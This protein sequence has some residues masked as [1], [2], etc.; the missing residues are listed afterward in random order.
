MRKRF[1]SYLLISALPLLS[2]C[3]QE[4]PEQEEESISPVTG[5]GSEEGLVKLEFSAALED[6]SRTWLDGTTVKWRGTDKI[7]VIDKTSPYV[8][9]FDNTDVDGGA[10]CRFIG[11]AGNAESW[12]VVYPPS[13]FAKKTSG[14]DY[15]NMFWL[16]Y[17]SVQTAVRGSF[18]NESYVTIA[19]TTGKSFTMRPLSSLLKITL[20]YN[21]IKQIRVDANTS[22]DFAPSGTVRPLAGRF[23]VDITDPYAH[24]GHNGS[25]EGIELNP[26]VGET[27]FPAG[28]YYIPI[29]DL[30]NY[31][32]IKNIRLTFIRQDDETASRTKTGASFRFAPGEYTDFGT[33][34]EGLSWEYYDIVF[35]V[36]GLDDH[37]TATNLRWP[38]ASWKTSDDGSSWTEKADP[39]ANLQAL[40]S[41]LAW[42]IEGKLKDSGH[43]LRLHSVEAGGTGAKTEKLRY[44]ENANGL[45]LSGHVGSYI[46]FPAMPNR[47]LLRVIVDY[48]GTSTEGGSP[49]MKGYS[50]AACPHI[51]TTAGV[52]ADYTLTRDADGFC[53]DYNLYSTADG[54]AYRYV[55]SHD[56]GTDWSGPR[57]QRIRLYY[58]KETRSLTL[59]EP[60]LSVI[61]TTL[62]QHENTLTLTGA[63]GAYDMGIVVRHAL[64]TA[65]PGAPEGHS[66][67]RVI[68][69][70]VTPTVDGDTQ[71]Y[72][73]SNSLPWSVTRT[74]DELSG[75]D[76][77]LSEEN[78]V[79]AYVRKFGCTTDPR[80]MAPGSSG[81]GWRTSVLTKIQ[82]PSYDWTGTSS[83][84]NYVYSSDTQ[85]KLSATFTV[86]AGATQAYDYGF[87]YKEAAATDTP[88]N[89]NYTKLDQNGATKDEITGYTLASGA[90]QDISATLTGLTPG[91]TYVYRP[92]AVQHM[93]CKFGANQS[94]ETP[95][96]MYVARESTDDAV[97][98]AGPVVTVTTA[99]EA[100][101]FS[102]TTGHVTTT[103]YM[104]VAHLDP[105]LDNVGRFTSGYLYGAAGKIRTRTDSKK[106]GDGQHAAFIAN[107]VFTGVLAYNTQH[108]YDGSGFSSSP[109]TGLPD[110]D[111]AAVNYRPYFAFVDGSG[112]EGVAYPA[113]GDGYTLTCP[114]AS[115]SSGDYLWTGATS[116]NL[117]GTIAVTD[118]NCKLEIGYSTDG[119]STWT[120]CTQDLAAGTQTISPATVAEGGQTVQFGVRRSGS[121]DESTWKPLDIV[122]EHPFSDVT[123][124][125]S[126]WY[127]NRTT[128]TIAGSFT[129]NKV[130]SNNLVQYGFYYTEK[131]GTAHTYI[132]TA[133]SAAQAWYTIDITEGVSTAVTRDKRLLGWFFARLV[134][135]TT[136]PTSH[137]TTENSARSGKQL[138]THTWDAS[139]GYAKRLYVNFNTN[140]RSV[141]SSVANPFL[142]MNDSE[143]YIDDLSVTY[144]T[145]CQDKKA[146]VVSGAHNLDIEFHLTHGVSR[147]ATSAVVSGACRNSSGQAR[148]R[149]Y[150]ATKDDYILLPCPSNVKIARFV[151]WIWAKRLDT[152]WTA[153][154]A[155]AHTYAF[156]TSNQDSPT[157]VGPSYHTVYTTEA[158]FADEVA[159]WDVS[160]REG[161]YPYADYHSQPLR[162]HFCG[163]SVAYGDA[164]SGILT[165]P[166]RS[167]IEIPGFWIDY[168]TDPSAP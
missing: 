94:D 130:A 71:T 135:S 78:E 66:Y 167:E 151:A 147:A 44:A 118:A 97:T 148:M 105:A 56:L 12:T 39:S 117:I 6:E 47:H 133:P 163:Q 137:W 73:W 24:P 83:D 156:I 164:Y 54:T 162:L 8:H 76:P 52:E 109:L 11:E 168:C 120:R 48:D 110:E 155:S 23:V 116:A 2:A 145:L 30:A 126:S 18:A 63:D 101:Y 158:E 3:V 72:V 9:E 41:S 10:R 82:R 42:D 31:D 61:S 5:E 50:A 20:A 74:T 29:A 84:L 103:A 40:R 21:N 46:E 149:V 28:D 165:D 141:N 150:A 160:L 154:E 65:E 102:A 34:D 146:R 37:T 152:Y 85:V 25:R 26:P 138:M 67:D 15:E 68:P 92:V 81:E 77:G 115:A 36:P 122:L 166:D 157:F 53:H 134:G 104:N 55:I 91:E 111:D 143:H 62:R 125:S 113:R 16:T 142:P 17:P 124:Y 89:W 112:T 64:E 49:Y 90:S 128:A 75:G 99:P 33:V 70:P 123:T 19:S 140:P 43:P 98:L 32:P 107:G 87:I 80:L 114:T 79:Y 22:S 51:Q 58:S 159:S 121:S 153:D 96:Y 100:H 129:T 127:E 161:Y 95:R 69:V 144:H 88:A 136:V 93:A 106:I 13:A 45:Y 108:I 86:T 35:A 139:L 1:F 119:G 60:T 38:F 7:A 59:P 4:T 132:Y 27:T 131:D 14:E 57:I